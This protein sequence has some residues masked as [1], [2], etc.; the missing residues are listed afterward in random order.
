MGWFKLG[1]VVFGGVWRGR[2]IN[3]E[4]SLEILDLEQLND[5][6]E[7]L[8]Y[9]FAKKS[10]KNGIIDFKEIDKLKYMTTRNTDTYMR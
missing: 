2:Y 9:T 8:C 6:R 10:I 3:Y 1:W 4:K 7:R 5:R